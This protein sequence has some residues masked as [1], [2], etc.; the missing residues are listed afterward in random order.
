MYVWVVNSAECQNV[1]L[2]TSSTWRT[3]LMFSCCWGRVMLVVFLCTWANMFP[4]GA[5]FMCEFLLFQSIVKTLLLLIPPPTYLS[6]LLPMPSMCDAC[7]VLLA[8]V[9]VVSRSASE[10]SSSLSPVYLHSW[11]PSSKFLPLVRSRWSLCSSS[12]IVS[13]CRAIFCV[14]HFWFCAPGFLSL[15]IYTWQ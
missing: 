5:L 15:Y 9:C 14:P 1:P 10:Q 3:F 6:H 13:R 7:P 12:V 2:K 4:L 11:H 8:G